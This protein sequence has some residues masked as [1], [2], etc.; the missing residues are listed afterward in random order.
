M[1]KLES[2]H[3][4]DWKARY[5]ILY[6]AGGQ[7]KRS[8]ESRRISFLG[9]ESGSAML[10]KLAQRDQI[11]QINRN[12][13]Q[14]SFMQQKR[15]YSDY[16]NKS[17]IDDTEFLSMVCAHHRE[18]ADEV[19][20]VP[21]LA[22]GKMDI[23]SQECCS[24]GASVRSLRSMSRSRVSRM[25]TRR[26]MDIPSILAFSAAA[27]P[28][29]EHLSHP[30]FEKIETQQPSTPRWSIRKSVC[31]VC[32]QKW[33]DRSSIFKIK[34]SGLK[35]NSSHNNLPSIIAPARLRSSINMGYKLPNIPTTV[36]ESSSTLKCRTR[37]MNASWQLTRAR[38]IR[39]PKPQ[40]Q[41]LS[42]TGPP[43][44]NAFTELDSR[45]N[46]F[47]KDDF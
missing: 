27:T 8:E 29:K 23:A 5:K 24:F 12:C 15:R 19:C 9:S 4:D 35:K 25:S 37:S 7:R 31:P 41:C 16:G 42:K 36:E 2:S 46:K 34:N 47:M 30:L 1:Q 44:N 21:E 28:P 26:D 13:G 38:R 33:R 6:S 3:K 18:L 43:C 32:S 22:A 20:A 17:S 40:M 14:T 45:I 39:L 10:L 11:D